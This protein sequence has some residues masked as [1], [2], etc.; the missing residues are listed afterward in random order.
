MFK[1][2]IILGHWNFYGGFSIYDA[3]TS[4]RGEMKLEL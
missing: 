2:I 3:A 4:R 1:K